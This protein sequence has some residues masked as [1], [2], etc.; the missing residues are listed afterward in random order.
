[1]NK[2]ILNLYDYFAKHRG[3]M[4]FVLVTLTLLLGLLVTR[5]NYKEDI[6]DFLPLDGNQQSAM[7]MYQGISGA[8]RI[9][10]LVGTEKQNGRKVESED[11][12][13]YISEATD[14]FT[15][16]IS[17]DRL[18]ITSSVDLDK[19]SELTTFVYDNIPYFLT[20]ADY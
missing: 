4:A 16:A 11:N 6:T 17:K 19:V 14:A 10:I 3:S 20:A 9:I 2:L 5:I 12:A 7:R 15:Q 13:D 8:N 18:N 1:M